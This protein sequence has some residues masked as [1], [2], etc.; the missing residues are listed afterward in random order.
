M[1]ESL[2]KDERKA[3]NY[4]NKAINND[5]DETSSRS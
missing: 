3:I 5:N 1:K 4:D 2:L